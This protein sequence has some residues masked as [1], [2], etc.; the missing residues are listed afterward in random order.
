[1]EPLVSNHHCA[2]TELPQEIVAHR[3][4]SRGTA[5]RNSTPGHTFLASW[6]ST[7]RTGGYGAVAERLV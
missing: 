1:V 6:A 2:Q 4:G 5:L 3:F 7:S